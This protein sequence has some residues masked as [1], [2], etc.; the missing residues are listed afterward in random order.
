M[1][2]LS[3]TRLTLL[4]LCHCPYLLLSRF[5]LSRNSLLLLFFSFLLFC[6]DGVFWP[7]LVSMIYLTSLSL[8]MS[9]LVSLSP[10]HV[11]SFLLPFF[12]PYPTHSLHSLHPPHLTSPHHTSP[13]LTSPHLT[14]PTSP[15]LT[16]PTSP[17]PLSLV[18]ASFCGLALLHNDLS[19][20]PLFIHNINV[21]PPIHG[22]QV[23]CR[24][25]GRSS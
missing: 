9:L 18:G 7:S 6:R 20:Q 22:L 17:H 14:T 21:R 11:S 3:N 16:T 13:H 12:N 5:V 25:M 15:H 8:F 4:C 23:S 10:N 24:R 19:D 2:V 1:V